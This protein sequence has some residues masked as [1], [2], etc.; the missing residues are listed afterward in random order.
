MPTVRQF[1][2]G[3]TQQGERH[4]RP[5]PREHRQVLPVSPP[6]RESLLLSWFH[7]FPLSCNIRHV[8]L[9]LRPSHSLPGSLSHVCVCVSKSAPAPRPQSKEDGLPPSLLSV[10]LPHRQSLSLS[11]CHLSSCSL[12]LRFQATTDG[13]YSDCGWRWLCRALFSVHKVSVSPGLCAQSRRSFYFLLSHWGRSANPLLDAVFCVF[14][15]RSQFWKKKKKKFQEWCNPLQFSV[16]TEK[17]T[18]FQNYTSMACSATL[19]RH[20]L[21]TSKVMRVKN[22]NIPVS[23]FKRVNSPEAF[24]LPATSVAFWRK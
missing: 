9:S 20:A 10:L 14:L 16:D 15:K 19:C 24:P 22:T 1:Q 5:P 8:S 3:W 11:V 2:Q 13:P 6:P 7:P 21:F 17:Y 12:A 23:L 4:R 18:S